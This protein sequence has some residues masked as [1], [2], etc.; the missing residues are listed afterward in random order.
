[1]VVI[2]TSG[3]MWS[4]L[5]DMVVYVKKRFAGRHDSEVVSLFGGSVYRAKLM[6]VYHRCRG[7]RGGSRGVRRDEAVDSG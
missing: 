7:G 6:M 5:D 4:D 3:F 2:V 1:M